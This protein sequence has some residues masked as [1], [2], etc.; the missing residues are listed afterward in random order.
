MVLDLNIRDTV[1]TD[2]WV[3]GGKEEWRDERGEK[4]KNESK[5]RNAHLLIEYVRKR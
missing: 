4:N 1:V 3:E 5:R 2:E